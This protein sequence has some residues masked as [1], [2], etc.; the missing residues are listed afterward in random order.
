MPHVYN[1]R[2]WPRREYEGNANQRKQPDFSESRLLSC[3]LT[4]QLQE[5]RSTHE[6][7]EEQVRQAKV[8]AA[9]L[10]KQMRLS[11]ENEQRLE[12][13]VSERERACVGRGCMCVGVRVGGCGCVGGEEGGGWVTV[14]LACTRLSLHM[15]PPPIIH[16]PL[17]PP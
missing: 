6:E 2:E 15:P 17:P 10:C 14:T 4:S 7:T 13:Q 12:A 9:D 3:V 16:L 11:R 1:L 5:L 8:D